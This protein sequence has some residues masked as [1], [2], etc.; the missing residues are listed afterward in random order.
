MVNIVYNMKPV[1]IENQA[2][3][4]GSLMNNIIPAGFLCVV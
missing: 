4:S 3:L 1:Q 2:T